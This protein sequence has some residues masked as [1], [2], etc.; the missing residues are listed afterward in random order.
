M[1]YNQLSKC[2]TTIDL[3]L[4][5]THPAIVVVVVPSHAA[6]GTRV[7]AV[8]QP[9]FPIRQ[10]Q[11]VVQTTSQR[12]SRIAANIERQLF[13]RHSKVRHDVQR[14]SSTT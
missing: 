13:H 7:C 11:R 14:I 9:N 1:L 12:P 4:I 5:I 2:K 6:D 10:L 8:A 3:V